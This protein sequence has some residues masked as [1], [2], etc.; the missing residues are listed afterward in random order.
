MPLFSSCFSG[1]V[2]DTLDEDGSGFLDREEMEKA[3]GVLGAGLGFIMSAEELDRQFA[4]MDPDGD[5]E[6]TF[7]EFDQWWKGVEAEQLV[8]DMDAGDV[9]EA[10][11]EAGIVVSGDS[12][13]SMLSMKEALK[14][15]YKGK[16]M[17]PRKCCTHAIS[18]QQLRSPRHTS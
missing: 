16:D 1:E 11:Q 9:A 12:Q 13:S 15:H 14:A 17:T 3:S 5:G 4:L 7:E 10:L 8:G 18:P 6:V 2:F